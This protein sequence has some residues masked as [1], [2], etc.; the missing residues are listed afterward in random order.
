MN[1]SKEIINKK[2]AEYMG[3][4][5]EIVGDYMYQNKS[6]KYNA[7]KPYTESLDAL[8]PVLRKLHGATYDFEV[9]FDFDLYDRDKT[10]VQYQTALVAYR[11]IIEM[12][13]EGE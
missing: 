11:C 3:L 2:L 5:I 10:T 7:G 9:H 1:P 6:P 4:S 13:K 8:V 12:E